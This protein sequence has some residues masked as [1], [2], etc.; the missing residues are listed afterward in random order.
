[1][2][3]PLG[4]AAAF[5]LGHPRIDLFQIRDRF[6]A[7]RQAMQ[8]AVRPELRRQGAAGHAALKLA[9]PDLCP[10]TL[11]SLKRSAILRSRGM[12]HLRALIVSDARVNVVRAFGT[13]R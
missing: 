7:E 8:I 4:E 12:R 10:P 9:T 13:Q 5:T 1:R 6:A 2:R 3:A 11:V